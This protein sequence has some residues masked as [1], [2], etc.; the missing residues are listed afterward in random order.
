MNQVIY[1][2]VILPCQGRDEPDSL[3]LTEEAN[4]FALWLRESGREPQLI[5]FRRVSRDDAIELAVMEAQA[6]RAETHGERP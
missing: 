4:G 3:L 6:L 1:Q 5:W 2:G